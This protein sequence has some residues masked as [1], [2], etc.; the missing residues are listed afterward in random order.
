MLKREP[1]C[2]YML[3]ETVLCVCVC[4]VVRK[5]VAVVNTARSD[6]AE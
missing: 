5:A 2:V 1:A 6:E 3:C 4:G